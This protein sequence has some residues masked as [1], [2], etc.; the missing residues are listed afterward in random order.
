MNREV[1]R[2]RIRIYNAKIAL[3]SSILVIVFFT[4]GC[5]KSGQ[6][7]NAQLQSAQQQQTHEKE[8]EKLKS[9]E[10]N[11]ETLFETLG[12]PSVKMEEEGGKGGESQQGTQKQGTQQQGTQQQGT[13]QQGTQ[14][15]GTQQ[16]TKQQGTQQQGTQQGTKQQGTQ[17]QGTQQGANRVPNSRT[18]AGGPKSNHLSVIF[19]INGM[20]LCR[21]SLKKEPI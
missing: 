3:L 4:A 19:I 16:G 17:Q 6:Q 8:P 20:I 18:W 1:L 10:K 2:L 12:G 7:N 11:L 21:R 15:Q 13:K 14:Q 5:G 9:I